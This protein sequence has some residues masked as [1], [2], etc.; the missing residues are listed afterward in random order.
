[1]AE[2]VDALDSGSSVRKD[3][4]VRVSPSAPI[5]LTNLLATNFSIIT[6]LSSTT[7]QTCLNISINCLLW[8]QL[9]HSF[10]YLTHKIPSPMTRNFPKKRRKLKNNSHYPLYLHHPHQVLLKVTVLFKHSLFPVLIPP[11]LL[12]LELLVS[13][14]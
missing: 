14:L 8:Q 13:V 1:M 2:L 3:V 5:F 7:Y 6:L 11:L 12:H 10:H 4:R 9:S